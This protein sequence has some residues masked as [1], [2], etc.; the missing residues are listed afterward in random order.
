VLTFEVYGFHSRRILKLDCT[1]IIADATQKHHP[2]YDVK[3]Q[4]VMGCNSGF[5]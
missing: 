2:E 3:P 1:V 5:L 4:R